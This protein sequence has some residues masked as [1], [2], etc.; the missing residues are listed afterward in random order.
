MRNIKKQVLV[1]ISLSILSTS[2]MAA[3]FNC[4]KAST[5][6]EHAICND[7]KLSEKDSE[8]G[9]A[10]KTVSTHT[11]IKQSQRHWISQRNKNCGD[12]T[13]CLY[14]EIEKRISVLN[15]IVTNDSAGHSHVSYHGDIMAPFDR[16][17]K[18]SGYSFHL[19]SKNDSSLN[20]LT[21]NVNGG[22][23][24]SALEELETD[25]I[26]Y[27]AEIDDLDNN[28]FP[29]IYIYVSS[30][31]SGSYGSLIAYAVNNGK[32]I[33]PIY[34][35]PLDQDPKA[36]IGY[37]GHDEFAVVESTLARRF[38][39]YADGDSNANPN[40]KTRQIDYQLKQGE[41][42]WI[43]NAEKMYTY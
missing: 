26:I 3:S 37:M 32:S 5:K 19:T 43:L 36:S 17:L 6:I 27:G 38:P 4:T 30:A 10:Y 13:D 2:T 22:K 18:Q 29:E 35:P 21:I 25:G 20:K 16:V 28:G 33:S 7:I 1:S 24:K 23:I 14:S 31:G 39:I 8:M 40:G 42:G 15:S 34:L 41:A 11:G 9:M 12:N